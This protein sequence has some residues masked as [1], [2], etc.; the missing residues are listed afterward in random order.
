MSSAIMIS[1]VS[2]KSQLESSARNKVKE[3]TFPGL[4]IL[5][6]GMWVTTW[7]PFI[8]PHTLDRDPERRMLTATLLPTAPFDEFPAEPPY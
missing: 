4:L 2:T 7:S 8:I 6:R 3:F 5:K 1:S